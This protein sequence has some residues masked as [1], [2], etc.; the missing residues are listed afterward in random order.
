METIANGLQSRTSGVTGANADSSR[1]HAILQLQ[2]KNVRDQQREY[3]KMSFIDLAGSERGAD[4]IDQNKQTRLDGAEINKSLL[5]LKECI[6]ALDLEKKHTPFRGSKLTQVL[7]DSF[8]GDSK[9]T[10]IANVSPAN[11]CCEHTLNTLRYADRV[12]ELKKEQQAQQQMVQIDMLSK[13]LMLA[14]QST[15][16]TKIAIN[17][18]TLQPRMALASLPQ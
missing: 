10:M 16:I 1:S 8:T 4:T 9:T 5:A 14:R 15:N 2:L 12:K 7:K 3:G 13:Q 18:N 17:Q 6:R 11:S